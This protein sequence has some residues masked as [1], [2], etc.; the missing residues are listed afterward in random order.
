[1]LLLES[2]HYW[3]VDQHTCCALGSK[4]EKHSRK[5]LLPEFTQTFC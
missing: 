3:H 1:M 5:E 2:Q 4:L